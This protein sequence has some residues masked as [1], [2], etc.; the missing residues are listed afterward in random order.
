MVPYID[1]TPF[2]MLDVQGIVEI[3]FIAFILLLS[4]GWFSCSEH[5]T[6]NY[7]YSSAVVAVA[8][9]IGFRLGTRGRDSVLQ[10]ASSLVDDE[11]LRRR[12]YVKVRRVCRGK[13]DRA[14]CEMFI[15]NWARQRLKF[16]NKVRTR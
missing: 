1:R 7:Y 15:I 10:F 2:R 12:L 8:K 16:E 11:D 5:V 3:S 13:D 6:R 4:D 9:F 14:R